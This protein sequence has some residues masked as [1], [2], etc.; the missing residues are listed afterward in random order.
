[1]FVCCSNHSSILLRDDSESDG[2]VFAC[3]HE[4]WSMHVSFPR[5]CTD[6][7]VNF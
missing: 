7:E 3:G 1:M 2:F 5:V 4:N 6:T